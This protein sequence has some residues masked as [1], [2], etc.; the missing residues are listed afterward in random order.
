MYVAAYMVTGFIVA[1]CYAFAKLRGNWTRYHRVAMTIP[2]TIACLASRCSCSS[3][4]GS[5]ATSR[6][7]SRSS[8]PRSRA[9]TRPPTAPEHILGWYTD[10]QVKYGIGIPHLLSLLAF[11]SWNAKMT[12]LSS[13]PA[14]NRPP[15][16]N[17]I[18]F[19]FQTMVLGLAL[20]ALGV[21]YLIVRWRRGRLPDTIWFYRGRRAGR[22]G[23]VRA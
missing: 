14:K 9:F 15:A 18:R 13:V 5:R 16:I 8:W 17:L 11:H 3:A 6:C 4:T 21:L 12:G 7:R 1:G 20:A 2:L 22:A 23:R 10:D 19:A